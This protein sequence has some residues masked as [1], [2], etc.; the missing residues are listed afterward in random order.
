MKYLITGGAGFI[1]SNYLHYVVNKYPNDEFIC[2][3]DLTY[4]GNFAN[5][6]PI[7][8]KKNFHFIKGNICDEKLIDELFEQEKFDVVINFAAESHVDNSIKNPG[9]FVNTNVVGTRV[10]LDA[11][12]RYNVQRYHQIS[13]DEVFGDLP[14]DRP[15]LKFK[16]TTPIN[17]SSPYSAS[18]ASADMLVRAY[19]R[20][21]GLPTTI[22][23]CSNNYGPYQFPEKLIPLMVSKASRDEKLPVYGNGLNVR[24]WI[25]VYDH[26]TGVDT[27]VRYGTPGETYN[28]GGHAEKTNI[29]IVRTILKA[30]N[31]SEDLITYVTDRPGHDLRYAMDSTKVENELGWTRKY[32]FETGIEE[33]ID[34]YLSNPEWINNILS[35]EYKK[36][37]GRYLKK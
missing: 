23:R 1:G 29:E 8:D 20:T 15:D 35:G 22:S 24:D 32:D 37:Y 16:E 5:L 7:I 11:A 30:L 26:N 4:A 34:W 9:V 10:L 6:L 36:E 17:P 31:K 13:T 12:K 27:I 33:T 28:L 18:K 14:L 2:L 3:D 19:Y 25:H 21:Y